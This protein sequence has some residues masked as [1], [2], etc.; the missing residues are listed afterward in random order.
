MMAIRVLASDGLADCVARE[1][2][3]ALQKQSKARAE[4]ANASADSDD[5]FISRFPRNLRTS[6][7]AL[8]SWHSYVFRAARAVEYSAIRHQRLRMDHPGS[9]LTPGR[10]PDTNRQQGA[11]TRSAA[12]AAGCAPRHQHRPPWWLLSQRLSWLD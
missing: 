10:S 8:R 11:R 6:S 12:R 9:A 3:A 5:N 7:R 1:I 2:S 4:V